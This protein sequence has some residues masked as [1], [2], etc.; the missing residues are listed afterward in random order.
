MTLPRFTL[1]RFPLPKA[2]TLWLVV[3]VTALAA[4]KLVYSSAWT[5][6]AGADG[7]YYTNIVQ[8]LLDGNGLVTNV[9]LYHRGFRELPHAD[10][11]YPLW[12][13]VYAAFA[14]VFPL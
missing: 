5:F 8:N 4:V 12:P 3:I 1:P 7:G 2:S 9:S 13:L 11:I 6:P 14:A 10:S